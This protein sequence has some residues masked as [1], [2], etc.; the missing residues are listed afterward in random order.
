M[1]RITTILME[2]EF[3]VIHVHKMYASKASEGEHKNV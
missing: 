3:L 1:N 2:K